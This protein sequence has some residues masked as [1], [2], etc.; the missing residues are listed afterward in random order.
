MRVIGLIIGGE[1]QRTG[2][3]VDVRC[4]SLLLQLVAG[5][6]GDAQFN[7]ISLG[8]MILSDKSIDPALKVSIKGELI[9][10]SEQSGAMSFFGANGAGY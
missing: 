5:P 10:S 2:A 1:R 3:D 6:I 9:G 4:Y 7:I 8:G